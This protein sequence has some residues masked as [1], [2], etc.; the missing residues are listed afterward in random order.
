M[1]GR[2]PYYDLKRKA[3]LD[4]L[5]KFPDTGSRTIAKILKRD[6]PE[7]FRDIEDARGFIRRYRGQSGKYHRE[8]VKLNQ[9]FKHV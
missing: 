4:L 3:V 9:Y 6:N 8:A 2:T 1:K 7:I 5:E